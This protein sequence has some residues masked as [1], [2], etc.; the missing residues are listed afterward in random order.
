[1][2]NTTKVA[3][4]VALFLLFVQGCGQGKPSKAKYNQPVNLT[5]EWAVEWEDTKKNYK[6]T[7][8]IWVNQQN[9][10]LTGS[11][12]DPNLI[13]AVVTGKVHSGEIT[14]DVGPE[15]G[16]GFRAPIPPVC[17]FKGIIT[18]TNSMEGRYR[19]PRQRGPWSAIRTATGTNRTVYITAETKLVMSLTSLEYDR[20][21]YL[22]DPIDPRDEEI[23]ASR[24]V[25]DH[26]EVENRIGGFGGWLDNY[27]HGVFDFQL[28]QKILRFLNANGYPWKSLPP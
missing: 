3:S 14:F 4:F 10:L 7:I 19:V 16:R 8:Y 17:T 15:R 18:S 27:E 23:K 2:K 22:R 1:M 9:D 28:K 24:R 5:G 21:F 11:A 13:P 6:E 12:L 25:G 26:Y 20:L